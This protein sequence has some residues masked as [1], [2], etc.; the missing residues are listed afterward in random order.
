[1]N[2]EIQAMISEE[3]VQRSKEYILFMGSSVP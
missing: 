3:N 2:P 1:M